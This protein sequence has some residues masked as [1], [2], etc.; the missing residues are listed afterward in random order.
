[1]VFRDFYKKY[2]NFI[3]ASAVLAALL[4]FVGIRYDYYYDLNDDVFI[5]DLM[6]GVYTGEPE[7]HNIQVLYPLSLGISLVYRI[8][9]K[10]PVY[11]LFLC[12]CQYGS[13]W[14]MIRRSLGFCQRTAWKVCLAA[15]EGVMVCGL[16]LDHLVF[17]Q[18]TVTAALLCAAAAFLFAT[19]G[20][21]ECHKAGKGFVKK[22]IPSILLA[23]L[24]FC[25]RTEMMELL[26]PL[27]C[28]AGVYRW[29]LE[30]GIFT[31]EN[32][33]KYFTVFGAVLAGMCISVVV[34]RAAFGTGDWKAYVDFFNS[35]T[36]LYDF[37]GIPPY[38]GNEG[39][40]EALGM[41]ESG[42]HMLLEE[43]N[44][45]LDDSLDGEVL[46]RV[47][48]HQ[49]KNKQEKQQLG[50]RIKE[51]LWV[52]TSR[53]WP[54]KAKQLSGGGVP[55]DYPWNCMVILGYGA[56]FL[57]AV[58]RCVLKEKKRALYIGQRG[59]CLLFLSVVRTAL[60][61]FIM[62]RGREPV[63]I[64]HSLYLME[65]C[66]LLAML[67]MECMG[68]RMENQGIARRGSTR[69]KADR[70]GIRALTAAPMG[71][72]ALIGLVALA[73]TAALAMPEKIEEVDGEYAA[74]GVANEVY[75]GM[76]SYARAHEDGFY[77]IDVYSSVSYP[78]G[79]YQE[80]PYSEKMFVGVDNR[81]AN[82]DIMGGWLV[83]SPSHR[84]KLEH[85]GIESMEEGLLYQE[86]VYLMAELEKGTDGF[87]DYF[88]DKG[89]LVNIGLADEICGIIGVYRVSGE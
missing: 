51:L 3:L 80:T 52:Y 12:L 83:K 85:F 67:Y 7:G 77:F 25:L 70:M 54:P 43:Y 48:A 20:T 6:A 22:N 45:G 88:R 27:I 9:P 17:V 26:L 5:K 31:K 73:G 40:Y 46:D 65:L 18:Y 47:I 35:R 39:L 89:I 34:D 78:S 62:W 8:F 16:F 72:T 53:M 37:Q 14:L 4:L 63:R 42:Q 66:I 41:S 21:G 44:F 2:E 75:D 50:G 64:T 76:K 32:Y 38:E 84:K 87:S 36:E 59:G 24:A 56:V 61:M 23:V 79:S 30:D 74:R 15:A 33:R 82:Y 49:K 1:M 60:W 81:L 11:G 13:F 10:A 69:Q 71:I 68:G 19:S 28:V 29:V 86:G 55:Y 57:A 58:I